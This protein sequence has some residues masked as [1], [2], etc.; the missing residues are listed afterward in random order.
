MHK[1]LLPLLAVIALP[2]AAN[3]ESIWLVLRGST[4][5][6]GQGGIAIEKIEMKDMNQCELMGA[7][8]IGTRMTKTESKF[9]EH[10]GFGFECLEGK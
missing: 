7:K 8:W 2:T 6:T 10:W 1:F 9:I 4:G 5:K 3:A